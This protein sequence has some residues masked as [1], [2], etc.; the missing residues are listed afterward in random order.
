MQI[1][2]KILPAVGV[3]LALQSVCAETAKP[4]QH[5]TVKCVEHACVIRSNEISFKIYR[6]GGRLV[7][8]PLTFAR[9]GKDDFSTDR[10]YAATQ[11]AIV[12]DRWSPKEGHYKGHYLVGPNTMVTRWEERTNKAVDI[13]FERFLHEIR[14]TRYL[15]VEV[16]FPAGVDLI[17]F[18]QRTIATAPFIAA[19]DDA[20]GQLSPNN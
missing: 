17:D 7:M 3:L 14:G 4:T 12:P 6:D 5:Y 10:S 18:D 2:F 11:F 16:T 9:N 1:S 19:I 15:I 8:Q 20:R 13:P